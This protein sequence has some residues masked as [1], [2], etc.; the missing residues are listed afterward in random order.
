MAQYEA[1][2]TERKWQRQWKDWE[3]YRFDPESPAPVY[4]IDNPPRYASGALHL[5]HATGYSLIDFAARYHR[6]RGYNVMF[7][8]CFDVNGTPVE[9]RVERKYGINKYSV[10]RQRY[11]ELC[12]EY[13][14]SF[15]ESMTHQF[16]ILGESMDPSLY[17]QTDAPY[18]R[19]ITQISFLRMLEKG[20]AYKGEYPVNWCPRCITAL[21]DAEV[22]YDQNMT[23]LN[24]VKFFLADGTGHII[25]A[26]TRPELICTC[27]TI[28]VHPNDERYRDLVGKDI[29]TPIF[30][31]KVRVIADEKV[32]PAFG[33]GI[34]MIC[35]IGDKTDLE[36]VM[37]YKLPLEKGLDEEGRMTALA[38]PYEGMP[39]KEARAKVIEDLL[40]SGMITKQE[41]QLQ[42]RS[43]CWRCHT[44]IEFLQVKQWFIKIMDFKKEVLAKADEVQWFPEFMKVRLKD[45]VD[46]LQWDWVVSRQRYFATPIPVWECQNCDFVLPVREEDC[47]IDPTIAKPYLDRCPRCGGEL[48][49][50]PDVFDTWMDSSVSPLY[51]TFWQRDEERFRRLYPMSLRPQSHDIIRTWAFYTLLRGYHLT[52]ERPWDHIMI[53]GFIMAPDGT[54]MHTSLGNVIDPMPLLE[55]YGADALRYYACTCSLGE[56]HA[57][58]ER[59]VVHGRKLCTK[60][61][62]LGKL[63]EMTVRERPE[64]G[65]LRP[66]DR[67]IL[68]R[69]T[70]TLRAVTDHLDHYDFDK[71]MREV[72]GFAWKEFADHYVEM[73]KHRTRGGDASVRYTLYTVY[74]GILKMMAPMLPH[75]TED[76]YQPFARMD[77]ARSVHVSKWPEPVL[78]D[79]E[80]ERR[81]DLTKEVIASIRT[82]KAEKKYPL[83]KEL[84]RVEV[85][86]ERAI[87]LEGYEDDIAQ[88]VRAGA[89][90]LLHVADLEKTAVAVR[91]VHSRLGPMF[92]DR[93]KEI[94]EGLMAM[95]PEEAL[96]QLSADGA[97]ELALK[98]GERVRVTSDL[99]DVVY[100]LRYQGKAVDTIQVGDLLVV[101]QV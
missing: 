25:V 74:L 9:V 80:A 69:F 15:I 79:E 24:Y 100:E 7:P 81:G 47:Y 87:D 54:P 59:D 45:W 78:I 86:G 19:R 50:C 13:A 61:W 84:A 97:L 75:V 82:W 42:N 77:G 89:V 33:S 16:E 67:W 1:I 32:D 70:R 94:V 2:P 26:T 41:D 14:N 90:E 12:E 88:T 83:N 31:K 52:G 6:Q 39:V 96:H 27:Q 60:V 30:G 72:E 65:E 51:N 40:A 49:G 48:K 38:G 55:T 66:I 62:N 34:V 64:R 18:Y 68:S 53:H 99:V 71:A 23:K 63:I 8:L 43:I 29:I 10:P 3:L 57:F 56:D 5:G 58:R 92:K 101:V 11:I 93:A 4:S 73:T 91:P 21:A 20:L 76:A 37:K 46:S 36:W 28:A 22:E 95:D 85:V 17:Y 44:P 35:T 98:D